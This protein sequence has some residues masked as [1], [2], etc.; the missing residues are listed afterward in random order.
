MEDFE[1]ELKLGFIEETTQLLS[2]AEQCFLVL[3]GNPQ[4]STAI[5]SIFRI[6]H[7]VKG[8]S[9]AVGFEDLGHF[10]HEFESLLL[11]MKNGQ[12][13]A[14]TQMIN[15]LLRCNDHMKKVVEAL[16]ED[17]NAKFDSSALLN[18]IANFSTQPLQETEVPAQLE[19]LTRKEVESFKPEDAVTPEAEA[20]SS[21][22]LASP[23]V[24]PL[25]P[26]G[27]V[28]PETP[29]TSQADES[30][31]VN[32]GR[33]ETLLNFIGEMV[34]LQSVIKEYIDGTSPPVLRKS[35]LQMTKVTKEIHYLSMSLRMV[36]LKNTFLKM[37]RIVR[38]TSI[39]VGKEV[40][41]SL[42]GEDTEVDKTVL[43]NL[44][45]PIVHLIR[46]AIDHGIESEESRKAK[47][48]SPKGQVSLKAYH[49]S[50][51]LVVEVSDDGDGI[52]PARIRTK[53]IEKK[54]I[55]AD[56]VMQESELIQLIFHPGFSTKEQ[57][58]EVSGRGVGMDVV[59]TNIQKLQGRI[60]VET[61]LGKG[62]IFRVTL[63]LSL[64]I[65]DGII[66]Q[67]A[68]DRFVIPMTHV[69]ESI[70]INESEL[71]KNSTI[72]QVLSLRGETIPVFRLSE[73]LG[74]RKRVSSEDE[75]A[76]IFKSQD[77]RQA[78]LV[79][80]LVGQSQVVIKKLG[81]EIK[82]IKGFSGSTI[83][84]DGRPA[85]ILELGDLIL[86]RRLSA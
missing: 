29:K 21:A 67:S 53:A 16:K 48:K 43:E 78:V 13:Q 17:F 63:P 49:K 47:G 74:K 4:D 84:G 61:T 58:S 11:K 2:E 7:N 12:I 19:E 83:L 70:R 5:E 77:Q 66:V 9:R 52:D 39:S 37:Q 30:I 65:I 32:L 64:A 27:P 54:L 18:E 44:N 82:N 76:V 6:V 42:Q 35:V 38:D 60:D 25:A 80:H 79:D 40:S 23:S 55:R 41:L 59:K 51:K 20:P 69:Y 15:L 45:D 81:N 73:Q 71:I 34:I 57:V 68:G 50:G 72:G 46:N 8:S 36:P 85:L 75:I 10:T 86:Q 22:E 56:A 3:E 28:A 33:L 24:I 62:T 31:R 26:P 14:T 1:K